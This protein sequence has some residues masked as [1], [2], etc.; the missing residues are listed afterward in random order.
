MNTPF[1]AL[2]GGANMDL[3]GI[4]T[5]QTLDGDSNPG[6][7]TCSPGGVARNIAE[8]LAHLGNHCELIAPLGDDLWG[9]QITEHCAAIGIGMAHCLISSAHRTS[10]YLS[11]HDQHGELI[12]ALNDMAIIDCLT[13]EVLRERLPVLQQADCW[14]LDANLSAEALAF[15]F[16]QAGAIPVWVDPVSSV[17]AQKLLPHLDQIYCMTPNLREAALLADS[18]SQHYQDAPELTEKL[19]QR[20]VEKVMITLGAHGAYASDQQHT[21]WLPAGSTEVRNVTGCG[22]SAIAALIHADNHG[23]DWHNSGKLAMAAAALTAASE[24]ANTSSLRTLVK[25]P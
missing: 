23:M 11:M 21:H 4:A 17:K 8:N 15:L 13:V 9:K 6:K 24:Q 18:P 3:T 1:I 16:T 14:V 12:S 10:T 7:V 25:H 22:D 20:G 2:I 5:G 19:H